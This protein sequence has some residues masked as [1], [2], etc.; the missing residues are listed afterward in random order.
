MNNIREILRLQDSRRDFYYAGTLRNERTFR[1]GQD[2]F[3][4]LFDR[5]IIRA[6]VI[7]VELEQDD[8]PSHI[9]GKNKRRCCY[10]SRDTRRK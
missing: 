4:Q 10:C 7:G 2:V 8:N 5:I 3:L 1:I 6:K 9:Q